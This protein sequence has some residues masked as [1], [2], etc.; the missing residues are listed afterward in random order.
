MA[1]LSELLELTY[2]GPLVVWFYR[3]MGIFVC[4]IMMMP[5]LHN[6]LPAY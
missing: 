6:S 5:P 3:S 4:L 1:I 2:D